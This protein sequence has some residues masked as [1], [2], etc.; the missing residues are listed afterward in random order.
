MN[1]KLFAQSMEAKWRLNAPD[2]FFSDVIAD[3]PAD[4]Q[5][6]APSITR[7]EANWLG[8][9]T[10][11]Y[12]LANNQVSDILAGFLA[13]P[14][15]KGYLADPALP[16]YQQIWFAYAV[17]YTKGAKIEITT[18]EG[19]AWMTHEMQKMSGYFKKH[20]V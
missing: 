2:E 16:E 19:R 17:G 3:A 15:F 20:T 14:K 8:K 1:L 13:T 6:F 10:G 11:K 4:D 18:S 7:E 12:D 5:S 9:I